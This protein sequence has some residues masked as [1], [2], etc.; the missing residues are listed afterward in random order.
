MYKTHPNGSHVEKSIIFGWMN[1]IKTF[2]GISIFGVCAYIGNKLQ[3]PSRYI[4]MFFIYSTF[5]TTGSPILL[6]LTIA[7]LLRLRDYIKT[8]RNQIWDF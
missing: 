5:L 3:I 7:F 4:K 2:F 6:Y 8:K 1:R